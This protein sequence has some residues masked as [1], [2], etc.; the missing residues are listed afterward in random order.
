[1]VAR[2]P[3]SLEQTAKPYSSAQQ[4]MP[5]LWLQQFDV[6]STMQPCVSALALQ[7]VSVL[8]ADGVGSI[9][10]NSPLSSIAKYSTCLTTASEDEVANKNAYLEIF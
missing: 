7:V 1:M 8:Q 2:Y 6:A 10:H 4:A 5:T 9:A 3:K